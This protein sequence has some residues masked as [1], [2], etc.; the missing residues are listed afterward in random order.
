MLQ[1][2]ATRPVVSMF[3]ACAYC[4]AQTSFR[5]L[6]CQT[7][8]CPDCC[9]SDYCPDCQRPAPVAPLM[10]W[11]MVR[12]SANDGDC[13]VRVECVGCGDHFWTEDPDDDVY[14]A[15]YAMDPAE[16]AALRMVPAAPVAC[17][18]CGQPMYGR[19]TDDAGSRH[20]RCA[21]FLASLDARNGGDAIAA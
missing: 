4:P 3:A 20:P 16:R 13:S 11:S 8:I 9:P 2:V 6:S 18:F 14:C 17:A 15:A 12:E 21:R 7:A 1:T 19:D 5:C 10:G